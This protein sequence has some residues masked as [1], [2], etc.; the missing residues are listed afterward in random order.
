MKKT[1]T[2]WIILDLIFLVVFNALFFVLGGTEHNASAWMSYAFIHFAYI[3][4]LLTPI[5]IRKGRSASMFG[6]SLLSISTAYFFIAFVMGIIFILVAPESHNVTLLVQLCFAGLYGIALIAN[7]IA[8]EHTA[9]AENKRL[10]EIAFVKDAS[11]KLKGLLDSVSDLEAKKKVEGVHDVIY[12]S[13]VKS[14]PNIAQIE[15]R[16][17]LVINDLEAEI[18]IRNWEHIILIADSLLCM[19][20]DRNM[21][22]KKLN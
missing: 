18:F 2:L 6:F 4:L 3:M 16:I 9:E 10:S 22:L 11:T 20:N 8:N 7:M 14:H 12:S 15:N 17:L 19:V 13:P 5:M 1:V 21:Q